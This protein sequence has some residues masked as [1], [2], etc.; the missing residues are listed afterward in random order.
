[1]ELIIYA[2]SIILSLPFDS[3]R[4]Y[5]DNPSDDWYMALNMKKLNTVN[6]VK[7]MGKYGIIGVGNSYLA[8]IST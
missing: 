4:A 2:L 6:A 5:N 7:T 3:K 1:L 8:V